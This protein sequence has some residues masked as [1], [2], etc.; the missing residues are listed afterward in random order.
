[1]SEDYNFKS[2]KPMLIDN[3]KADY[4]SLSY[5]NKCCSV[6]RDGLRIETTNKGLYGRSLKKIRNKELQAKYAEMCSRLPDNIIIEA[7]L[8]SPKL[9]C[10]IISGIA[11]SKDKEVPDH[12]DL[13]VFDIYTYDNDY[14]FLKRYNLL[15]EYCNKE[16][17]LKRIDIIPLANHAHLMNIYNNEIKKGSEGLVVRSYDKGYKCTRLSNKMDYC[18][19]M[20]PHAEIDCEIVCVN[21]RMENTNESEKNELGRSFKRNTVDNK[22]PTGIA[23]TVTVKLP[24]GLEC[25]ASLKGKEEDRRELWTNREE[26]VGR[27][28]VIESMAYGTK[29]RLRHPKVLRI[30]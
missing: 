7:E 28:A 10:R 25:K 29:D 3:E 9:P 1:M 24:N 18:Y 11:N 14:D 4:E 6:K 13:Y 8:W 21:E 23:A 27:I 20:K 15:T 16:P 12:L 17:L 19:K 30:K 2:F 26:Y 22:K 5:T